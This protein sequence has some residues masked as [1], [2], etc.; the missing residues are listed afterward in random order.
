M[1]K[2]AFLFPGQGAQKMDQSAVKK[3]GFDSV[4]DYQDDGHRGKEATG[5]RCV[6]SHQIVKAADHSSQHD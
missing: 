5:G 1:S 2:T 3:R 6:P 4:N